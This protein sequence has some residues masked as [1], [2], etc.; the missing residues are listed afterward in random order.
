MI[1]PC[2]AYLCHPFSSSFW[3]E[4]RVFQTNFL[5]LVTAR[6]LQRQSMPT[7][8]C[9]SLITRDKSHD[10]HHRVYNRQSKN[11][12][13]QRSQAT[14]SQPRPKKPKFEVAPDVWSYV[15]KSYQLLL[16][17]SLVSY[18]ATLSAVSMLSS[19][20]VVNDVYKVIFC[21]I[22]RPHAE[23]SCKISRYLTITIALKLPSV[24]IVYIRYILRGMSYTRNILRSMSLGNK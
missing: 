6:D 12:T 24:Y 19:T 20:A 3:P 15:D 21:S 17:V 9:S 23:K 1:W 22:L 4:A 13:E 14:G 11:K 2:H 18:L 5:L 8:A 10:T 16:Q 7:S